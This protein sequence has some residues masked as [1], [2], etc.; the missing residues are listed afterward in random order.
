MKITAAVVEEAKGDFVIQELEM[1]DPRP[2]EVV[3]RLAATGV[4]HT[5]LVVRDQ[6]FPVPLPV[7]LGHEGAGVVEAVGSA[8]TMVEPGDHVVMSMLACRDCKYCRAGKPTYCTGH[9][10]LNFG[11]GRAD[12][13]S[14]LSRD[15]EGVHG[16]FFSQ[17][18][19]ASHSLA[20]ENNVV[21][22]PSD[23]PLEILGPLACGVNTGAGAIINSLK[24]GAG[25]RVAVF[26]TGAV[27]LSSVMAARAVGATT[28][29]GIDLYDERL[30]L[31]KELG[32]THTINARNDDPVAAIM[33]ITG[34]GADYT[35]ETTASPKVVRQAVDATALQGTCALIGVPP[36]GTEIT[37]DMQHIL[38]GRF[39]RGI[40][41]GDTVAKVFIPQLI[42]LWQQGR[43]PFDRLITT[44]PF[45]EI[46]QAAHDAESGKTI[47][48]VL[49]F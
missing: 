19:F 34:D 12:G 23:A 30:E 35:L 18:S 44:Y 27:G 11:G 4:C 1:D 42:E 2:D 45:D 43:F 13:S 29:I 14:A 47:K 49:T 15:G 33:D 17:S 37:L 21:K 24:V 36:T 20:N 3:V 9:Y 31:A 6:W 41:G 8:V 38:F 16:H 40:V 7:V 39:L 26:G 46:N 10:A 48:P 28:I 22:V 5:D 32:A 25:A